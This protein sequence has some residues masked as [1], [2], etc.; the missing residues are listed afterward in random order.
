MKWN[1]IEWKS[2]EIWLIQLQLK[3]FELSRKEDISSVFVLQKQLVNHENVKLLAIRKITQDN[4]GKRTAGVDGISKLN[5]FQRLELLKDIRIGNQIDKIRKVIISKPSGKVVQLRR[6]G[7]TNIASTTKVFGNRSPYDGKILYWSK[8]L[9][10]SNKY[11]FL[12]KT[13]LKVKGP[14]CDECKLYFTDSYIVEIHHV[15]PKSLR[16]SQK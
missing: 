10:S 7:Q 4:L 6:H 1:N 9:S 16:G 2:K 12:L 13:L 8:R 15:L 5:L 11:G 3:I 14:K